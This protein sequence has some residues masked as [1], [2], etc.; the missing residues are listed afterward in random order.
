MK[1]DRMRKFVILLLSLLAVILFASKSFEIITKS[2][3]PDKNVRNRENKVSKEELSFTTS[4]GITLIADV[5][6]P[7]GIDKTPTILVRIPFRNTYLNRLRSKIIAKYWAERGYT[8]VIQGTRGRYKSTGTYYPLI[9]EDKD[10]IETL[11]WILERDWYNGKIGMWGGSAFGYTQWVLADQDDLGIDA[12]FIQICS[13]DMFS[14]FYPGGAFSLESALHW[15]VIDYG[16]KEISLSPSTAK[17]AFYGFPLIETDNRAIGDIQFFNDWALNNSK[18]EYWKRIDGIDRAKKLNAPVLLLAGWY[19]AFL[20]GQIKDFKDI[21]NYSNKRVASN[22]QLIIGP[23]SHARNINLPGKPKLNKY[24]AESIK[25]SIDWFD[26]HLMNRPSSHKKIS[27]IKIY[28]MGDNVWREEEEWPLRRTKFTHYY[29]G[30]DGKA[31]GSK[32]DGWLS[33][34]S[35]VSKGVPDHYIY[36]PLDPVPSLGGTM[37]GPNAGVYL[38]NK[39]EEND[40]ILL[41]TTPP[42]SEDVEVTGPIE[43]ILYVGTTA[44]NT[45]F[46]AKIVDVYPNDDAYNVTDG[47][48][49]QRFNSNE[50]DSVKPI[51]I[52]INLWPTSMVFK[53]G[54]KIRLEVSSSNFPRFDR[55][56][57]TGGKIATEKKTMVARQTVYHGLDTPSRLVLPIIPRRK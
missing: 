50:G 44:S 16:E 13:T 43:L 22:S 2:L 12:F 36:N 49:R 52:K 17:K 5:Y 35:P 46:T 20:P 33:I 7:K 57:N 47:I 54:H 55:N 21:Q 6:R 56:P 37:L 8:V 41:Y 30:S 25:H 45:D 53:A 51:E 9:N 32:G 14:M 18:K 42:L 15:A 34:D 11:R 4:D 3:L 19:D 48:I 40:N 26:K 10:G 23:W 39:I 28:V 1:V 38:Q 24:R 29:I 27:P 31:N